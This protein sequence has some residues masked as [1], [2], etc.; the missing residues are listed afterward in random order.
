[1]VFREPLIWGNIFR[2]N[3]LRSS[4]HN[5]LEFNIELNLSLALL[6]ETFVWMVFK[7][8]KWVQISIC[9]WGFGNGGLPMVLFAI[10]TLLGLPI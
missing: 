6:W 7:L 9:P 10:R 3:T 4:R 5:P 1:M 2:V 8:Q